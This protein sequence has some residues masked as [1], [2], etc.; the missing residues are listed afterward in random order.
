MFLN[1]MYGFCGRSYFGALGLVVAVLGLGP[2]HA[3]TLSTLV[4]FCALSDCADGAYPVAGLIAD[5]SGNL[6][7]TTEGGGAYGYGTVFLI[8]KT[9]KGYAATPTILVS[10][11]SNSTDG[12]EPVAGLA[13]DANGNLFGTTPYGGLYNRGTVFK[14]A[15]TAD[16]YATAATILVSFGSSSTDGSYPQTDLMIDANGN[17][18]GTTG[19]G[20]AIVWRHCV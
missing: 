1:S 14:V 17:L 4:S 3:A 19:G 9:A 10:F 6:L 13:A 2:S 16:G 12:S 7:G 18:F 15:K 11:G 5:A 20:W 8:A